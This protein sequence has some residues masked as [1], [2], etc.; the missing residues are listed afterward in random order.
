[1]QGP[2]ER[3]SLEESNQSFLKFLDDQPFMQRIKRISEAD[4]SMEEPMVPRKHIASQKRME[5]DS[6]FVRCGACG[7]EFTERG[8]NNH[9]NKCKELEKYYRERKR[10][11]FKDT[12]A[13]EEGEEEA[14]AGKV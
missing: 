1:M 7:K 10:Q 2:R 8:I 5:P 6:G 3:G 11:I 14:E 12:A 9:R 4:V 13:I